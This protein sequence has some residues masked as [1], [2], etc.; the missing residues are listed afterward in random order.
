MAI[1]GLLEHTVAGP[2]STTGAGL[3]VKDIESSEG[4]HAPLPV[5]T[6][7]NITDPAAVSAAD[8]W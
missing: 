2:A 6:K 8:G 3:I 1:T 4:L 7:Y 5:V